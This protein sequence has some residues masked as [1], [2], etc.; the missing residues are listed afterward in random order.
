MIQNNTE[1]LLDAKVSPYRFHNDLQN[2]FLI[3]LFLDFD[4]LLRKIKGN[5]S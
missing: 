2:I 5:A 4:V 1:L 3:I